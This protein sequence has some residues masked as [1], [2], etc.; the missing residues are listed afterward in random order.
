MEAP[1][2]WQPPSHPFFL[3]AQG[4]RG[5]PGRKGMKGQKGEPGPPGLDQPCPV[6][7][8]GETWEPQPRSLQ[9]SELSCKSQRPCV[10]CPGVSTLLGCPLIATITKAPLTLVVTP[11][12]A[13]PR[14][15]LR[16][17]DGS[18]VRD[19][20]C[21]ITVP[22]YSA[23]LD[24]KGDGPTLTSLRVCPVPEEAFAGLGSCT[25]TPCISSTCPKALSP[26]S[27]S[28]FLLFYH[29]FLWTTRPD[30]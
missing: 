1:W 16:L 3:L 30:T 17:E 25:F 10:P 5:V 26:H 20:V 18:L 28:P 4:D 7:R 13:R 14:D 24:L 6:V 19:G 29:S 11:P 8:V 21:Q 15:P 9:S 12:W 22:L 2:A 27:L 23:S